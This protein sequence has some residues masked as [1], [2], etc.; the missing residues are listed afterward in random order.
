MYD[1]SADE[2]LA[3]VSKFASSANH[4]SM[5][6]LAIL[7]H[8][9]SGDICGNDGMSAVK[10]QKLVDAICLPSLSCMPKVSCLQSLFQIAFARN[11]YLFLHL[12]EFT[13]SSRRF[14]SITSFLLFVHGMRDQS[15]I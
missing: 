4:G 6:A 7:S 13:M 2:M 3:S 8:G 14:E 1:L 5:I 10:V 15:A 11:L 9:L 12:Y